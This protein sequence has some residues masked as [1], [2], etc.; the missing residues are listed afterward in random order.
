MRAIEAQ[1]AFRPVIDRTYTLDELD[2][3]IVFFATGKH[4]G[5]ISVTF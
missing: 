3:A 2:E 1:D 5:K 4:F